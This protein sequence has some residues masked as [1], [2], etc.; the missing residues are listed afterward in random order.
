MH[1]PNFTN[2]GQCG[3]RMQL[4][5]IAAQNPWWQDRGAIHEDRHLQELERSPIHRRPQVIGEFAL[6]P[7]LI[8]TLRGPRQVGKTTLLKCLIASCLAGEWPGLE[9]PPLPALSGL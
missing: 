9:V 6:E 7:E 4:E 2:S 3:G 5:R 8:Y 1:W